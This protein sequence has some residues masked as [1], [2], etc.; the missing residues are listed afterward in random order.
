M[1]SSKDRYKIGWALVIILIV[2]WPYI[3]MVKSRFHKGIF[4][5]ISQNQM[6]ISKNLGTPSSHPFIDGSPNLNHPAIGVP[7]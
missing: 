7:I 4:P 6:Q 2:S 1:G 3:R 5:Y